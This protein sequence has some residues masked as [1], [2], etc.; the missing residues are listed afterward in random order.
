LD[1]IGE[2]ALFTEHNLFFDEKLNVSGGED[3]KFYSEVRSL[4]L[5]TGWITD[6]HLYE[7]IPHARLTFRYQYRR[8]KD[9][10]TTSF[11][12]K[13]KEKPTAIYT[14]LLSIA[15]KVIG[16]MFLLLLMPLTLGAT[17]LSFCRTSGWVA[18]R[19]CAVRGKEADHYKTVTGE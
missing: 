17:Y 7:T 3:T 8:A 5:K 4:G 6:A 12:G 14:F 1:W 15:I 13:L 16:I 19:I 9:Q 11:R 10:S 2:V 18:G